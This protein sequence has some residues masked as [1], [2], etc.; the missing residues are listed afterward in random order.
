MSDV[1][2]EPHKEGEVFN[3]ESG[4][5]SPGQAVIWAFFSAGFVYLALDEV[6]RIHERM[7]DWI[8][9][10]FRMEKSVWSVRIDDGILILYV[11]VGLTM[12]SAYRHSLKKFLKSWP[13]SLSG[14]FVVAI[15]MAAD[16]AGA[17]AQSL[18]R[19]SGSA[20]TS[21]FAVLLGIIEDSCK[22]LVEDL[23]LSGY[24]KCHH[25]AFDAGTAR[26]S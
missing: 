14:F 19:F 10:L 5:F 9:A 18:I 25:L 6:L 8:H 15:M 13:F 4:V 26:R 1:V 16:F 23:F 24:Y 3:T 2:P 22:I 20:A 21:P 12:L 17:Y 11:V 7:D